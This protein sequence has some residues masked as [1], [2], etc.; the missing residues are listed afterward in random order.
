MQYANY[1]RASD[2]HRV[3]ISLGRSDRGQTGDFSGDIR[4]GIPCTECGASAPSY[5]GKAGRPAEP[6]TTLEVRGYIKVINVF[7][8]VWKTPLAG[9][10]RDDHWSWH[11]GA[12]PSPPGRFITRGTYEFTEISCA[13][14]CYLQ[15]GTF[16]WFDTW[17]YNRFRTWLHVWFIIRWLTGLDIQTKRCMICFIEEMGLWLC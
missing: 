4:L 1:K 3:G 8:C 12:F 2:G 5:V 6:R 9:L 13:W 16:T 10:A 17:L 14:Y 15:G 11:P 7:L